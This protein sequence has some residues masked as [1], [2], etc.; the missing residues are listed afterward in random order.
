MSGSTVLSFARTHLGLPVGRGEC[1]DLANEALRS[2]GDKTSSDYGPVG[3][4]T[5]Y[6]WG[7]VISQAELQPGDI[8]QFRTYH[9][10]MDE[11]RTHPDGSADTSFEEQDRNHHT[12]IV[13]SVGA[14]GRVTVYEQ[15]FEGVR[16]VA[17]NTLRL[18]PSSTESRVHEGRETITVRRT[19]T[20]SGSWT[21]YRPEPRATSVVP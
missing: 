2:G 17:Q 21:C 5:D 18:A 6:I 14:E 16:R 11:S 13:D 1:W 9:Y 4:T 10:R 19:I 3:P 7:R 15:N 12:A 8:I 20:V